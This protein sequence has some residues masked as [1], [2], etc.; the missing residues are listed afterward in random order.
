MGKSKAL[1]LSAEIEKKSWSL[2]TKKEVLLSLSKQ[3]LKSLKEVK[4]SASPDQRLIKE[5]EELI[6]GVADLGSSP[7][8]YTFLK[9]I[10]LF[11]P[12]LSN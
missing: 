2:F 7:K 3:L 6:S 4:Q 1:L 12:Y 5:L 10:E 9:Y 11:L 8:N